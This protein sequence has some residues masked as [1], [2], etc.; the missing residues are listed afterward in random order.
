[1]KT[2]YYVFV[3]FVLLILNPV[4]AQESVFVSDFIERLENSQKYVEQVAELMP[5]EKYQYRA[6]EESLSFAQN[7]MHIGFAL[8]W[9]S[10]TLLGEIKTPTWQEDT[11]YKTKG[12]SKKEMIAI[13]NATFKEAISVLKQLDSNELE[14]LLDYFGLDRTKRQICLLLADH[15]THHRAQMIVYLRLNGITPPRYVL[16]Q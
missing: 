6:S 11:V 8:N 4:N 5:A 14:N 10:K 12:K 2:P 3:F 1:M 7:L 9:H 13:V 16:Y 15:I